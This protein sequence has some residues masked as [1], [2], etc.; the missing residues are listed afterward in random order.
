MALS[1]ITKVGG[2]SLEDPLNFTGGIVGSGASFSGI[3]T[4]SSF[5]GDG[6]QLTGVSGFANAQGTSCGLDQVFT[7]PVTLTLGGSGCGILSITATAATDYVAF[8]RAKN[9]TVASGSTVAISVGTTV[10]TNILGLF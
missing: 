4:A 8:V 9:I 10:R 2:N 1:R 6:S 3:V 5:V 7:T